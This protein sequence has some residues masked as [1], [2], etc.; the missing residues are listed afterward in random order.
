MRRVER[1]ERGI[2]VAPIRNLFEEIVIGRLVGFLH[3]KVGDGAL[4]IGK[5][6]IKTKPAPRGILVESDDAHRILDFRDDG[7]RRRDFTLTM[8]V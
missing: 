4:R 3:A 7:E 6:Q 1:D 2:A 5:G 8:P